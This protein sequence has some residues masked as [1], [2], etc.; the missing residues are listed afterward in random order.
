M[1][2]FSFLVSEEEKTQDCFSPHIDDHLSGQ[3]LNLLGCTAHSSAMGSQI[4]FSMDTCSAGKMNSSATA[5]PS[6]L[7]T[8]FHDTS[9]IIPKEED[10]F[11]DVMCPS[12][13]QLLFR[14]A[15]LNCGHV[16]CESC[17]AIDVDETL[18]C[19]ICQSLHPNGCPKVCLELHN[20]LEKQ[21]NVEYALRREAVQDKQVHCQS[22]IPSTSEREAWPSKIDKNF[23]W[24]AEY[25]PKF[26]LGVGCDSCGVLPI[27]GD[28]Y[29]CKDCVEKI[30]FDLCGDCYNTSSKRPGQF[31]QQHKP[32]HKFERIRLNYRL[33]TEQSDDGS[34]VPVL[35]IHASEES[36]NASNAPNDNAPEVTDNATR[37]TVDDSTEDPEGTGST[38]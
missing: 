9:I 25:G 36:E 3:E 2:M 11:A 13:K 37:V 28:R 6:E 34:V 21:F 18:R 19:Q 35:S 7:D 22:G 15:V 23:S 12:C 24:L 26:H 14:P 29:R 27:I 32:E 17:I 5:V 4:I 10:I 33:E 30:G 8:S 20:F 38:I 31:N 16:I 1:Y